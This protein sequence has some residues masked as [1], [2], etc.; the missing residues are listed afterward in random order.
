MWKMD[1]K[2][3]IKRMSGRVF[4][5]VKSLLIVIISSFGLNIPKLY[6]MV[7]YMLKIW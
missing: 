2:G 6:K 7:V 1:K 5:D 4:G 3:D